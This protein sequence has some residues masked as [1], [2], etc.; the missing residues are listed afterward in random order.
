MNK[1]E[2]LE[3]LKF[4]LSDLPDTELDEIVYDYQEHFESALMQGKSEVEVCEDLGD[5]R[6]IARQYR[7][8][9]KIEKASA[10]KT[11]PN[12]FNAIFAT[13]ALGFFNVVIVLGPFMAAFG[14]IVGM[15]GA[16]IGISLGGLATAV[17]SFGVAYLPIDIPSSISF[18]IL[19]FTGIGLACLGILFFICTYYLL[20]VLYI[21]TLR[22]LKWN[23]NVIKGTK[24]GEMA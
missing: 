20:K 21:I 18:P 11:I 8:S 3:K 7:A 22:Y 10:N 23:L 5:V 9:A 24:G 17:S 14:I 1:K 6:V 13:V 16:S 2:F 4:M 19:F 15:F 12:I